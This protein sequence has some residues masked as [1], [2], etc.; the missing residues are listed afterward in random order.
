M[1]GPD[2]DVTSDLQP[3]GW[4]CFTG[5]RG[6]SGPPPVVDVKSPATA[7]DGRRTS[8]RGDGS[9]RRAVGEYVTGATRRVGPSDE[10]VSG[11][12]RRAGPSDQR[13]IGA[14]RRV[15]PSGERS[16]LAL[17]RVARVVDRVGPALRCVGALRDRRMHVARRVRRAGDDMAR[18]RLACD[19]CCSP[20]GAGRSPSKACGPVCRA[21]GRPCGACAGRCRRCSPTVRC[22]RASE[23][24]RSRVM[25]PRPRIM[26]ALRRS[27]LR[28]RGSM[29]RRRSTVVCRRSVVGR[30]RWTE[31]AASGRRATRRRQRVI[32]RAL[33]WQRW[34][35]VRRS[36]RTSWAVDLAMPGAEA[37]RAWPAES[38]GSPGAARCPTSTQPPGAWVP[39]EGECR[40]MP[41]YTYT[42]L[43][44]VSWSSPDA[45]MGRSTGAPRSIAPLPEGVAAVARWPIGP[46]IKR[47]RQPIRTGGET[48]LG[49]LAG[50]TPDVGDGVP[51]R[52]GSLHGC[53]RGAG[54]VIVAPSR[55]WRF[56]R[57]ADIAT[58]HTASRRALTYRQRNR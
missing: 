41:P 1:R 33:V 28:R 9:S 34:A 48:P 46:P 36:E 47:L 19:R 35:C 11:A 37:A 39:G 18:A 2:V 55:R 58:C 57:S 54:E 21:C 26:S 12:I 3:N 5:V 56:E 31:G 15:M 20:W 22:R 10:H 23:W 4:W 32:A 50:V 52:P 24:S 6:A 40:V 30:R 45:C 8:V 51:P 27:V 16:M 17:E 25:R 7:S 43:E 29:S 14:T 38:G 49:A 53:S 44:T 13:L 42:R